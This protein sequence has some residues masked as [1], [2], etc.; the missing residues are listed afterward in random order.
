MTEITIEANVSKKFDV[1]IEWP[2]LYTGAYLQ[3]KIDDL[4]LSI[5]ATDEQLHDLYDT[6][7]EYLNSRGRLE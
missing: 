5:E 4:N 7:Q 1:S 3:I 6:L 2:Y